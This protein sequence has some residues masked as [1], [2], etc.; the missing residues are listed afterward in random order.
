MKLKDLTDFLDTE[1]GKKSIKEFG[2]KLKR[3]GDFKK[4]W[5]DKFTKTLKSKTDEEL[6]ILFEKFNIHAI[7]RA[8]ILY[9]QHIDGQT[10]LCNPLL[11]AFEELGVE[12]PDDAY[13]MFSSCIFDW[14]GYRM[15]MYCGQGC[16]YSLTKIK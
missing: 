13:G 15:E 3:E 11:E 16:F 5:V 9:K 7:K 14:R 8:E 2:V 12:A 6:N 10:S 1:E 4:R